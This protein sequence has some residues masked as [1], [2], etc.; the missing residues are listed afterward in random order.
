[1]MGAL[2]FGI[3]AACVVLF[4]PMGMAGWHLSR[5]KMLFFSGALF[6]TLAVGVHLTPYFPSV[7]DVISSFSSPAVVLEDRDSC[8]SFLHDISW[9]DNSI[10]VSDFSLNSSDYGEPWAWT[11]STS[12]IACGF[13]K[14]GRSDALDLLN[15]SWVVIAGDSQ[16]RLFILALLNLML[17]STEME[18]VRRDL[19]KR[20]SDYHIVIEENGAKLDFIWAPYPMNLTGLVKG[21]Q[22]E[23]QY[24]DVL[25]MGSGLWHM[26]RFTDASDFGD[27]LGLLRRSVASLLPIV[28]E[29]GSDGPVT[30]SV[31]VQSPHMFWLGM[32]TL[33]NSMLNT[34]EKKEK[35]TRVVCNAY[36]RELDE[37]KLLRRLGGPFMLLDIES[38]SRSCGSRCTADGMH[39]SGVVYEAVVHIMLN[40]LLI[41]SRQ[42]IWG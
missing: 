12:V 21:F 41:E 8:T 2:Q 6:I 14:L 10:V 9:D 38:L 1:M 36:D 11:N 27:S 13:S 31:S 5:N 22:R 4:V 24:P 42:R 18:S 7:S 30:G 40:E 20:H 35:M 16:A 19:F 28:S 3:L 15:G 23:R 34:E 32:P 37:S 26:L 25:V 33:I 29:F 17:D 39:Y